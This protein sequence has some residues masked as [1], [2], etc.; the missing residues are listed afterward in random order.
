MSV[1]DEFDVLINAAVALVVE[2]GTV[3]EAISCLG[4]LD[5]QRKTLDKIQANPRGR[6]M[7]DQ[8]RPESEHLGAW[9][10]HQATLRAMTD[11]KRPER[12]GREGDTQPMPTATDGPVM[13]EVVIEALRQR[14][15]VGIRRYGQPLQAFN[16]R[17]AAQDAFEEILDLS[18]YLAQIRI[19]MAAM[20]EVL[21]H[22]ATYI[23]QMD[24]P[25]YLDGA[26]G[27]GVCRSDSRLCP[28]NQLVVACRSFEL[29]R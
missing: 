22:A 10:A 4:V 24:C 12:E 17:D 26:D 28:R 7:N 19:E 25:S 27:C 1:V 8:Q 2:R 23:A 3:E 29:S 18:V 13:H 5:L 11:Q 14:L 21:D 6:P 20:R 15:E 16:G 9:F